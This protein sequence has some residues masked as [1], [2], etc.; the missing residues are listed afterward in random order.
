MAASGSKAGVT[1]PGAGAAGA[2]SMDSQVL[3]CMV[4]DLGRKVQAAQTRV[5]AT[6]EAKHAE[7]VKKNDLMVTVRSSVVALQTDLQ[8]VATLLGRP[9]SDAAACAESP[10]S[11]MH[12]AV[13]EHAALKAEVEALDGAVFVLNTLLGVQGEFA[14]FDALVAA[15]RYNEAAKLVNQIAQ[16]LQR[17]SAPEA[18]L[19]PAMVRGT[20]AQYYQ[21]RAGLAGRLDEA[22]GQLVS[23]GDRCAT[24]KESIRLEEGA[25]SE[26]TTLEH[27]WVALHTLGLRRSKAELLAQ[28]A[29][30]ELLRPLLDAGKK[31]PPDRALQAYRAP[32]SHEGSSVVTRWSWEQAGDASVAPISARGA[33]G[34]SR[35]PVRAVL[36]AIESLLEFA[37]PA[38]AGGLQEVYRFLGSRFWP[39]ITR[40]LIVN[41]DT[42]GGDGGAALEAFEASMARS[43][44]VARKEATFRTHVCEH[45]QQLRH[46]RRLSALGE[47]R[48]WMLDDDDSPA[49]AAS[50]ADV[51]RSLSQQLQQEN[52]SH[53]AVLPRAISGELRNALQSLVKCEESVLRLPQVRIT[54]AADKL[55]HSMRAVMKEAVDFAVR[56]QEEAAHDLG[57]LVRELATL[58]AVLRPYT[59]K[60]QVIISPKSCAVLWADCMYMAHVLMLMPFTYGPQLP[61]PLQPIA[62]FGDL[63]PSIRSLGERHFLQMMMHQQEEL[64]S[65]L[66]PCSFAAGIGQERAFVAAEAALG[67][68]LSRVKVAARAM[69]APL[70]APF[71]REAVGLLLGVVCQ[72]LLGKVWQLRVVLPEDG[73]SISQL[74]GYVVAMSRPV[75]AAA[76]LDDD[77]G[78]TGAGAPGRGAAATPTAAGGRGFDF[79][80][81]VP[82][83]FKLT[84]V[85]DLF[86]S[87]FARFLQHRAAVVKALDSRE[88]MHVM[89]LSWRDESLTPEE[90][91]DVLCGSS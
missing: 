67:A 34:A 26:P 61:D 87:D 60:S 31:L 89:K 82:G 75:P 22:L 28:K 90:A 24:F 9:Q 47:A 42:C 91:W 66:E 69:A 71:H 46:Q 74:L 70:P 83:W 64:T 7:L 38:W 27:V 56:K 12:A 54:S 76:G 11:Q 32:T 40:S 88:A 5:I 85:A 81:E 79:D 10:V 78:V 16:T 8:H 4:A 65:A 6:I 44:F 52:I 55:A 41:F 43:G 15:G 59:Q 50:D 63:A 37:L 3:K 62:F 14:K 45:Q 57:L 21:R 17:V 18:S 35:P 86:G 2:E 29:T 84:V 23:F 73:P 49:Q 19:E 33:P 68:A 72:N 1:R 39:T 13:A 36:P 25:A 77:G 58:F 20:K 30:R 51:P 53:D 48:Q 80:A